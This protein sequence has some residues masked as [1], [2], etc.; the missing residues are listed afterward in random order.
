MG[1]LINLPTGT[2]SMGPGLRSVTATER[3]SHRQHKEDTEEIAHNLSE[4]AGWLLGESKADGCQDSKRLEV[5]SE[6]ASLLAADVGRYLD[7]LDELT[8]VRT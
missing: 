4:I 3:A 7:T 6:R 2:R 5:L 1:R 8:V